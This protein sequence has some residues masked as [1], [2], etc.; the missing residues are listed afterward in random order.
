MTIQKKQMTGVNNEH[1]LH[2]LIS[3]CKYSSMSVFFRNS[4]YLVKDMMMKTGS[5]VYQVFNNI[6]IFDT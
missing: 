1:M 4:S 2:S 6:S 5:I 3:S